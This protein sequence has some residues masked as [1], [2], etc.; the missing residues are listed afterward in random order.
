MVALAAVIGKKHRSRLDPTRPIRSESEFQK[1]TLSRDLAAQRIPK[2]QKSEK[3][4]SQRT[5][6]Q[7]KG[8]GKKEQGEEE[9]AVEASTDVVDMGPLIRRT[10]KPDRTSMSRNTDAAD[11]ALQ[12]FQGTGRPNRSHQRSQQTKSKKGP[13][14]ANSTHASGAKGQST[15]KASRRRKRDIGDEAE[16]ALQN[17]SFSNAS[18]PR[19]TSR[20]QM[21]FVKVFDGDN[22]AVQTPFKLQT[23][24]PDIIT[25]TNDKKVPSESLTVL[26]P[27]LFLDIDI[28]AQVKK[29]EGR[30]DKHFRTENWEPVDKLKTGRTSSPLEYASLAVA[31][32]PSLG[33]KKKKQSVNIIQRALQRIPSSAPNKQLEQQ[34]AL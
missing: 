3:S 5:L 23:P 21:A 29:Y 11:A 17:V 7:N 20:S 32:N 18:S 31:R 9:E 28:S 8:E 22:F 4:V 13:D 14:S 30:Y 33:I 10:Q 1:N 19:S 27:Q 2:H 24:D 15:T 25:F 34:S 16:A 6:A 26:D 12:S